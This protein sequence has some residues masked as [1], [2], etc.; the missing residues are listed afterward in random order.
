MY[1]PPGHKWDF[2]PPSGLIDQALENSA[3]FGLLTNTSYIKFTNV[4][5]ERTLAFA[6]EMSNRKM[7]FAQQFQR[8]SMIGHK[9]CKNLRDAFAGRRVSWNLSNARGIPAERLMTAADNV[10]SRLLTTD[11]TGLSRNR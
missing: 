8:G 2:S 6:D 1:N 4:G 11:S 5:P 10:V 9:C 3:S 7:H